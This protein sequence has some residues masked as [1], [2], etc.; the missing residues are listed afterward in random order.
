MVFEQ[1]IVAMSAAGCEVKRGKYLA[2]KIPGAE[3]FIRV[4]FI[5]DDY[6][7]AR[8][9]RF[10]RYNISKKNTP[11]LKKKNADSTTVIVN[12]AMTLMR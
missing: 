1:F 8:I 3:R 9:K 10:Q 11:Y 12:N 7:E 4:K 5:G 2:F 6:T